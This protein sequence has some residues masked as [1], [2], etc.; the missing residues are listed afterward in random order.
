[1]KIRTA[2]VTAAIVLLSVAPVNA[3]KDPPGSITSFKCGQRTTIAPYNDQWLWR[4]IRS[5]PH[6]TGSPSAW[7]VGFR[8]TEKSAQRT[9]NLVA[10]VIGGCR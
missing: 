6:P 4:V 10:N 8:P 2:I 5:S 1:M 3:S 7:I 9:A